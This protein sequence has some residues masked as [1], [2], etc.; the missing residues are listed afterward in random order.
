MFPRILL[1]ALRTVLVLVIF[2]LITQL[3]EN[4]SPGVNQ[5][6]DDQRWNAGDFQILAV[7]F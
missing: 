4:Q 7:R 6:P 2:I 3:P 1:L 5:F